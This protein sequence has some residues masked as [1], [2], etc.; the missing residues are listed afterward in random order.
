[1]KK[2]AIILSL[3]LATSCQ[4]SLAAKSKSANPDFNAQVSIKNSTSYQLNVTAN[5]TGNCTGT[6]TIAAGSTY[7][8]DATYTSDGSH[9]TLALILYTNG[10]AFMQGGLAFSE[11][12]GLWFDRGWLP[13]NAQNIKGFVNANGVTF[14][15]TQN[16]GKQVLQW[17]QFEDGGSI[18]V[19]LSN[20]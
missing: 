6:K 11:L 13:A 15:Q 16:G 18:N 7:T 14:T 10:S 19:E 12:G 1:M 2:T 9:N 3:I 20:Q 8:C 5:G 4:S 17:N